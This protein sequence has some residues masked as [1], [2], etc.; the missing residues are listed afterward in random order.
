M[1]CRC[2]QRE[3]FYRDRFEDAIASDRMRAMAGDSSQSQAQLDVASGDVAYVN[4]D[5]ACE[6]VRDELALINRKVSQTR[7]DPAERLY[8]GQH[9]R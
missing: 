5:H 4:A 9:H 3:E 7:L 1:F 2:R 8:H 6:F